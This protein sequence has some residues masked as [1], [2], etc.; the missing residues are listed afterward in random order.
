MRSF[1]CSKPSM[2]AVRISD[3]L[4]EFVG[5]LRL[6]W[7]AKCVIEREFKDTE[8]AKA[9][10]SSHGYFG[11]VVQ[12]F[13][14]AAGKLFDR[15]DF[16]TPALDV[17]VEHRQTLVLGHIGVGAGDEQAVIGIVR[18]RGPDLLAVDDP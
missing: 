5:K 13:D 8:G 15:L 9:V 11:F 1:C 3:S 12:T 7:F 17:D 16:D 6:G 4:E 10:R 14:Y 2:A 18:A